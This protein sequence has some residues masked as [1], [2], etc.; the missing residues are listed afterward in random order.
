[1]NLFPGIFPE[2]GEALAAALVPLISIPFIAKLLISPELRDGKTY[3]ADYFFIKI[4]LIGWIIDP[5]TSGWVHTAGSNDL[6]PALI[7]EFGFFIQM[8]IVMILVF[9]Y[10]KVTV[11]DSLGWKNP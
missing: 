7:L 3:G 2:K 9:W 8:M 1:M 11:K 6:L 5:F 4:P 10:F